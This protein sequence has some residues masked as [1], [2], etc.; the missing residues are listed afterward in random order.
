LEQ[1]IEILRRIRVTKLMFSFV[2]HTD[3]SFN[4]RG[5][6]DRQVVIIPHPRGE[7]TGN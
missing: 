7:G 5:S 2:Y 3:P 4:L 1:Y 6:G